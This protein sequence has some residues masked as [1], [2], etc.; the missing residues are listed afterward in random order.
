VAPGEEVRMLRRSGF[1]V[2]AALAVLLAAGTPA[3]PATDRG[4]AFTIHVQ[5]GSATAAFREAAGA[6]RAGRLK[7]L[8]VRSA[9]A[10]RRDR[11]VQ[12]FVS[13][14]SQGTPVVGVLFAGADGIAGGVIDTA[15]R[16]PRSYPSLMRRLQRMLPSQ[17]VHSG[18][19]GYA[20]LPLRTV[21][22][23]SGTIGLPA[24]WQVANSF[25]GC[26]EAVSQ[27]DHGY[28]A[29]GC[30]QFGVVPPG[31]PGTNPRV[32][33]VAPFGNPVQML[34]QVGRQ[35]NL[36]SLH[37]VEVQPIASGLPGGRAAYIL[38]DYHVH[39]APFRGLAMIN[40]A[41]VDQM[42]YT[43]FKSMFMLPA[44]SFARLAP[45]MWRSWQSWGVDRG[46]LNGRMV[47]AAQSMREAGALITGANAAAQRATSSANAG[48]DEYIRDAATVEHI[49]TGARAEGSALS[50]Q[51]IVDRDPTKYRIVPASELLR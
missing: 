33:L 13:A 31:L 22:F 42:S 45:T 35:L 21:S 16:L 46:V 4:Q 3:V 19:G 10:D 2:A 51:A 48:F 44:N 5:R 12:A 47:A 36:E 6:L 39:G 15:A 29:L 7:N 50:A 27:Q 32:V 8:V 20:P 24:G 43:V 38:F 17:P 23:G 18:G 30:P 40:M 11:F 28:I 1:F 41:P 34:G 37:A 49:D 14:N 9:L 25:Q 26:V